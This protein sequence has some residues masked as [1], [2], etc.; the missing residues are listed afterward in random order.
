MRVVV[1]TN[2]LVRAL[3]K[4]QGT[5]GP[6]LLRLQ[7]GDFTLLYSPATLEELVEV[8]DR[9]RIRQK[10][11]LT[12]D[13]IADVIALLMVRGV[14]IQPRRRIRL[15]RD[16]KDDKFLEL[17]AAGQTDAIVSGDA[18]LLVLNPFEGIPILSPAAFLARLEQG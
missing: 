15:C 17:A 5:V 3:I 1:D 18:D 11:R 8:L 16:P 12:R 9:P 2:I 14:A 10:H 6:V 7:K 4:P 13:D